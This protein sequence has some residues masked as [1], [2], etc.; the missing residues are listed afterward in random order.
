MI[1][2]RESV[3]SANERGSNPLPTLKRDLPMVLWI[4]C[5]NRRKISIFFIKENNWYLL[6]YGVGGVEGGVN[7]RG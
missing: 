7:G 2:E 5:S 3:E 6:L 1:R 4:R